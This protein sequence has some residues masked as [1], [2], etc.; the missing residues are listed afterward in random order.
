MDEAR[1]KRVRDRV[2]RV[3]Q[4]VEL[5]DQYAATGG[6]NGIDWVEFIDLPG[7]EDE[8]RKSEARLEY[9]RLRMS[10]K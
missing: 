4:F 8:I 6:E 3:R 10:G 7:L 1:L 9:I 2:A 5:L